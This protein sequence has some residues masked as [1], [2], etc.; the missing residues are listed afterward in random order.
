MTSAGSCHGRWADLDRPTKCPELWPSRQGLPLC[1]EN[2]LRLSRILAVTA[3]VLLWGEPW[4]CLGCCP[5]CVGRTEDPCAQQTKHSPH[6]GIAA[7]AQPRAVQG[8][9]L[10]CLHLL[11]SSARKSGPGYKAVKIIHCSRLAQ[12]TAWGEEWGDGAPPAPVTSAGSSAL[13]GQRG[14]SIPGSSSS[15]LLHPSFPARRD[16]A[17]GAREAMRSWCLI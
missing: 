12:P 5:S 7:H 11:Q 16:S 17:P 6:A 14:R 1:W 8:I 13:F 3:V 2:L 15:P 4:T 9:A 10:G